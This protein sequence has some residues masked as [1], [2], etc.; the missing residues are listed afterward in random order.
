[1]E[2]PAVAMQLLMA[3]LAAVISMTFFAPTLRFVRSYWLQHNVPDWA[4]EQIPGSAGG[5]LLFN[6]HLLLPLAS[7]LL[8]VSLRWMTPWSE[9]NRWCA[10]FVCEGG[11]WCQVRVCAKLVGAWGC[12]SSL[13]CLACRLAMRCY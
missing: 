2:L 7:T 5:R 12:S 13:V 10:H 8:W 11:L 1:M 9:R 4:A 3:L 6:L